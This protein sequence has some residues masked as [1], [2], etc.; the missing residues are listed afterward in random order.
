MSIMIKLAWKLYLIMPPTVL[1]LVKNLFRCVD[2]H[3]ANKF[4]SQI[5]NRDAR[6]MFCI[7]YVQTLFCPSNDAAGIF[8]TEDMNYLKFA[9]IL[10]RSRH[11]LAVPKSAQALTSMSPT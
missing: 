10:I 6:G 3:K 7:D 5:T 11:G 2:G 1:Y 9:S 4:N 8:S